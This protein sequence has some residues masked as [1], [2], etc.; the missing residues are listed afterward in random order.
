M[1]RKAAQEYS[2]RREPWVPKRRFASPTVAKEPCENAAQELSILNDSSA[3]PGLN[4]GRLLTHGLRRGLYSCAASRLVSIA[5][6][7]IFADQD[8]VLEVGDPPALGKEGNGQS[9][10]ANQYRELG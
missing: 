2:P 3:P 1:S 10:E 5:S 6:R 9:R 4:L 8:G 7:S